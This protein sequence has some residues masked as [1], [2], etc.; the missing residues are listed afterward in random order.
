VHQQRLLQ[1]GGP[2]RPA[3]HLDQ[4][5]VVDVHERRVLVRRRPRRQVFAGQQAR[6]VPAGVV[7]ERGPAE[8]VDRFGD[9]TL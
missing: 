8:L 2:L 4:A 3:A 7:A 9:K 6:V 5:P 1:Q